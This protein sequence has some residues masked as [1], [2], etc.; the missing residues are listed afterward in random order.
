M[1]EGDL[2]RI[3]RASRTA[4][5]RPRRDHPRAGGRAARRT[6]TSSARA[7]SAA[8]GPGLRR[9]R[10]RCGSSPPARCSRWARCSR[11]A[12]SPASTARPQDTFCLAFPDR[13]LRR[14]D[15]VL[16]G[17]PGLLHAPPR[18]PARPVAHPAAGGV[19]GDAD[20]AARAGDA[21][22][23]AAAAGADHLRARRAARRRARRR[24]RST[25]SARC[26]S[27]TP[28]PRPLGIFT[29]QDVI[30]RVVLPQRPLDGADARRDERAG[31][32]AAGRSHRRR[33][34]A[35]HGAPRH[36]PRGRAATAT[37]RSPGSCPS[38]TSSACS[39]CRCASSRRRSGAPA[40]SRRWSS[41]P[42][43]SARC[44]TRWSRR[45]SPPGS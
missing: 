30:G 31:D 38:A 36:P 15:R 2:D 26:R 43:T 17:L 42:R 27:S 12:A 20:R 14:A 40:T 5:L 44:R 28:T 19:R 34:G 6:A 25:G 23:R 8:S 16:A 1:S 3:V 39:G 33:R 13:G 11:G 32:H 7:P 21:A 18:A 4:L 9:P 22:G 37:A 35:G 10:R 45:V 41:A 24:W 29:R